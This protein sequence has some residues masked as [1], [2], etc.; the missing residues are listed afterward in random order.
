L[1]RIGLIISTGSGEIETI[2]VVAKNTGRHIG[3]PLVNVLLGVNTTLTR[4]GCKGAA[5]RQYNNNG[6]EDDLKL[7]HKKI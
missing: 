3:A 2:I 4:P 1:Q 7:S 5:Y 6:N